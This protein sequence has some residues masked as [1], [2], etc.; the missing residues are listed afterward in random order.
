MRHDLVNR[1][2]SSGV[3]VENFTDEVRCRLTDGYLV[4]ELVLIHSDSLVGGLYVIGFEWRLTDNEGVDD[5]TKRPDI[6]LIRMALLSFE[7]LRSDIVGSTT[8]GSFPL[9]I[10]LELGGKT[11]ITNLDLHLVV[12]EKVAELE[13]S[14]NDP[15]RM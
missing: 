14:V 12:E 7:N 11:E 4:R 5:N 9:T 10:E 15:M 2:S 8:N 6:N 1:W 13:I 3:V